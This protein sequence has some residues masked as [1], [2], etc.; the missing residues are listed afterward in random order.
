MNA[1]GRGINSVLQLS[2][3][4]GGVGI[5]LTDIRAAGDP[6]KGIQGAASGVIP[7]MKI[8]EDSLSY[9]NQLGQRQGAGA[10]YLNIFHPDIINFLSTK[11]ENADEKIRMK[12]LSLGI[13]V[14]DKYY[15]LIKKDE[16]LYMFSPYDVEKVYGVPFS[17]VD[18]TAEYD[19]M[20]ANPNINKSK[21]KARNL[22]T[23][24]SKLQ[25]ESGYPYIL[26]VDTANRVNPIKGKIIMS[27]LCSEI[28]QVQEASELNADQTYKKLGSDISCNLASTNITNLIQATNFEKSVDTM[29]RAVTTV[30]D[31]SDI[32]E[33]PTVQNGNK[34]RHTIGI[35]AMGL[36]T[37]LATNEIMYGSDE[38][39]EFTD[40]YFRALNYYTL[41]AS[42]N[43][44]R[45]RNEVFYKFEESKYADGSYFDLYLKAPEFEVK[46]A[47]VREVMKNVPIPTLKDWEELKALIMKHGLYHQ[48]RLAIAP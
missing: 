12:T 38:S 46:S 8:L 28:L 32:K 6:I 10:V 39:L 41:K 26:N 21:I 25:Q 35:G 1:I 42:M 44:A 7:V 20:V 19:N 5:S 22:E 30:T 17:Q 37:A 9:S 34:L 48:N 40:I 15:E 31:K 4:G 45:E 18:I 11:K 14:P 24:I 27:N 43:I 23:E 16:M 2:R 13:V 3:M 47:K 29:V 36:H 33:V